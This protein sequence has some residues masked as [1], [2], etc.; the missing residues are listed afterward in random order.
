MSEFQL[1]DS[2]KLTEALSLETGVTAPIGSPGAVVEM[3]NNGEAY[4]VELFGGWVMAE[5]GKDFSPADQNNPNSFME[6]IGFATVYPY[7]I[8]LVK[9]VGE[10][11]GIRS[12]L[13]A[14]M[15]ELSEA[16]LE[17]VRDFAESL[18]SK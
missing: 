7:Q 11:N 3:F 9:S 2:I 4:L 12:Q 15:D 5:V 13:L 10:I 1:F 18:K 16:K 8:D 6:T 14:L 17:K